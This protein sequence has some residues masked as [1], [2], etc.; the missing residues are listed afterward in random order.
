MFSFSCGKVRPGGDD[1]K[2]QIS[3]F[4]SSSPQGKIRDITKDGMSLEQPRVGGLE[5][6]G[7]KASRSLFFSAIA[8]VSVIYLINV[9]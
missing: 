5:F 3:N 9:V 1:P 7:K 2:R 4:R 6:L 8:S